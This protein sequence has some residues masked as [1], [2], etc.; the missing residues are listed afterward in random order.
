MQHDASRIVQ[1]AI[2]FGSEGQRNAV[3]KE[4]CD[5]DL[6][7]LACSQYGHFTL[8]KVIKYSTKE[9]NNV[10]LIVKLL[11]GHI[12]KLAVHAVAARVIELL[13]A[14]FPS[15][16]TAMLKI[17]L[18]GPQ[19]SLFG[20]GEFS[21]VLKLSSFPNLKALLSKAPTKKEAA[22]SYVLTLLNKGMDKGLFG[23]AYF[24]QLF[25]DYVTTA[26]GKE[27][28]D[29]APSIVDNS[30]HML[31]TKAGARVVAEAAAY[32]TPKC[33]KRILKSLKGY[34]RSSLLHPDAYV[35]IIRVLSVMDDTVAIQKLVFA[36]LQ[37]NPDEKIK[38]DIK[39]KDKDS[40]PILDL[41]LSETGSKMFLYLLSNNDEIKK[42][43]F[44]PSELDILRDNPT[45]EG[46]PTSKKTSNTRR[47]ELLQFMK[48]LLVDVCQNH[49]ELLVY[50]RIGCKVLREVLATFPSNELVDAIAHCCMEGRA[51]DNDGQKVLSIFEHPVSHLLIKN[52]LLAEK[53]ISCDNK[54]EQIKQLSTVL[55]T[56][57][58]GQLMS[59][60]ASSNRGFFVLAALVV[61]PSV[62]SK[63]REELKLEIK[64]TKLISEGGKTAGYNALLK[65]L[66]SKGAR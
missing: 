18:Y 57:Y 21:D 11:K 65:V 5:G 2:Q 44:D 27:I 56:K 9:K 55:Y 10:N 28:M 66:D 38:G 59:V 29:I 22:L 24:Q 16:S 31:S 54:E 64:S 6:A 34:T 58:K 20:S 45:V 26:S 15:K 3:I 8:L 47:L 30:I 33:R 25:F 46:T 50:S 14:T 62:G 4:L 43:Y 63:V 61:S 51:M 42:R 32:G 53:D 23:F 1:A 12:P 19:F 7:E 37:Q 36:E 40:S 41:V 13:F 48:N 49:T 60:I 52:I 17:E 35:A 39:D